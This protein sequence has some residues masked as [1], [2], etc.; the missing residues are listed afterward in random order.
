MMRGLLATALLLA[1]IAPLAGQNVR[2][3]STASVIAYWEPGDQR[4]YTVE[5]VRTGE[6]AGRSTYAM[7]LKVLDATD[8]T[9][10]MECLFRSVKVEVQMPADT[11]QRTVFHH[12]LHVQ[13][14]MRVVFS[15]D[16]TG[17]PLAL[18][19]E[20]ELEEHARQVLNSILEQA[21]D[22]TE[23]LQMEATLR[24]VLNVGT[25]AQDALEDIGNI[26]FPFGVAYITGRVEQV[27]AEVPNPLGGIPFRT[28]QTFVME[29]FDPQQATAHMRM[30]QSIDPKAVDDDID[31]LIES[32]GGG[33]LEGDERER[34]R[35]IIEGI[36]VDERM[37]IDVDLE[38]AW[39]TRLV[40]SR[41]NV[42][43]N[44]TT[45]ET[46]TYKLR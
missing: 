32:S 21:G 41:E 2:N 44:V 18:V 29:R 1:A 31:D 16:E 24:K 11:R 5:R 14:G 27:E 23:R 4:S 22:N 35:R 43:R 34:F 6:R 20:P 17:I 30:R 37:E 19:N 33:A 40:L 25:L 10:L 12:L 42:V 9:Y 3:D 15:T 39:T 8:S 28:R 13:E 46:R 38:G 7:V 45:R 26:L 36:R